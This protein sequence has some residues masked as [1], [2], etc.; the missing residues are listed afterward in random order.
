[1]IATYGEGEPAKKG[2]QGRIDA[3]QGRLKQ[4]EMNKEANIRR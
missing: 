3:G 4:R 2:E 1:M